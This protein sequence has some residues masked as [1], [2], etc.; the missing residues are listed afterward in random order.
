MKKF[1]LQSF[2]GRWEAVANSDD[3]NELTEKYERIKEG[4]LLE[5]GICEAYRVVDTTYTREHVVWQEEEIEVGKNYEL[6]GNESFDVDD[7]EI[8]DSGGGF[9]VAFGVYQDGYGFLIGCDLITIFD[10]DARNEFDEDD[11]CEWES[12]HTLLPP[13]ESFSQSCKLFKATLRQIYERE[14]RTHSK[15]ELLSHD[16]FEENEEV[17]ED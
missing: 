11:P 12:N 9:W 5:H 10:E 17:I 14:R 2:V 1:E 6:T 8:F 13:G 15:E 4:M 16:I 3:L 7:Y